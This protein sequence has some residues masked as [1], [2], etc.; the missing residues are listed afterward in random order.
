M[1]LHVTMVCNLLLFAIAIPPPG[2]HKVLGTGEL[3]DRNAVIFGMAKIEKISQLPCTST[4]SRVNPVGCKVSH[5]HKAS[6]AT[7]T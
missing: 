6:A 1:V 5:A 3:R 7:H 4:H 2:E